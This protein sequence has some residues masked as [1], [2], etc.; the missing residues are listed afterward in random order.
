M[1]AILAVPPIAQQRLV[2]CCSVAW[3][4]R[5]P[6][7]YPTIRSLV[8]CWLIYSNSNRYFESVFSNYLQKTFSW[9]LDIVSRVTH[10]FWSFSSWTGKFSLLNS[11][12][13]QNCC[14]GCGPAAI[15]KLTFV[16]YFVGA[17]LAIVLSWAGGHCSA[18]S[19]MGRLIRN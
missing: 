3:D 14:V 16:T 5:T 13:N 17:L 11:C 9:L 10:R 8:R 6:F 18:A 19:S 7:A 2:G 15:M 1:I 12:W 4:D